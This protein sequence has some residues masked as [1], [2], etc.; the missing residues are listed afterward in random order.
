MPMDDYIPI[1]YEEIVDLD[2]TYLN[3]KRRK[4]NVVVDEKV[5]VRFEYH[6]ECPKGSREIIILGVDIED[7]IMKTTQNSI[8]NRLRMAN[9]VDDGHTF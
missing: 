1:D 2:E 7:G 3:N 8:R 4:S 6:N 5:M 9:L